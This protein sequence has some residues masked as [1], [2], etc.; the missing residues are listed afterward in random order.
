MLLKYFRQKKNLTQSEVAQ[1]LQI[2]VR[3]YQR[4]EAGTSFPRESSIVILE[5]LFEAP[6]RVLFADSVDDIPFFLRCFLP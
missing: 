2:S 1:K 6:H 5:D 3:Q 4:I